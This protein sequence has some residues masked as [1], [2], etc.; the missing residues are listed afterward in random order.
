VL[1]TDDKIL[2][3][4]SA[5]SLSGSWGGPV[6]S[7]DLRGRCALPGLC[8]AHLHLE[9]YSR[10]LAQV[11]CE[12]RG[13]EDCLRRV[14][15]RAEHLGPGEWILGH[16]WNHNDW[17]SYGTAAEL[18][19]VAPGHPV[20]LTAKSLHA[21]WVNTPAL[22]T[23]AISP[24]TPDPVGGA[25]QRDDDGAPTGILLEGAMALVGDRIPEPD[26]ASV[27]RDLEAAQAALWQFGITAVHDFDGPRC[28]RALQILRAEGRLGLH[29]LKSI[30]LELLD[31][32][33]ALGLQSGFGDDWLRL[34]HVKMFAD[35]ALGP[36]TAA[37]MQ[38]Y[39]GEPGNTGMGLIDREGVLEAG[40]RAAR[41]GLPLAI[42]AIGDRA[43][44]EVLEGLAELRRFEHDHGLPRLRHRIEHLQLLHPQDLRRP[45]ELGLVV[46]MQPIHATSDMPMAV[47]YWGDRCRFAYAWRTQLDSGALAA[48]GS[49]APVESPNVFLGLHAA[50]T[51]RRADGS[52]GPEGWIPGERI[53]LASALRAFTEGPATTAGLQG[54]IGRI[55]PGA[56]ADL[57]VLDRDP[58]DV[59]PDDLAGLRPAATMVAGR[60]VYP[61][62]DPGF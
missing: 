15:E 58:Y 45:S 34:G 28:F 13:R 32:A 18:D 6:R 50:V 27:A 8:D 49:D 35:G 40:I 29:V 39:D 61:G 17:G 57:V 41:G 47:R 14:R 42:H 5:S 43:N 10:S 23:A 55:A 4:G 52:P 1:I 59:P 60:W 36:R 62:E 19:R 38:A 16:G 12:T 24:S 44:H 51:R 21:A 25:I 11:D 37:M 30:P 20:Y 31:E 9:K 48:F 46:S 26:P 7:V 54:R 3:V 2:A 33:V 22:R 53:D 56:Y